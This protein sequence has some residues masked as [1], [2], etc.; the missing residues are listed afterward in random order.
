[1]IY[2]PELESHIRDKVKVL[3]GLPNYAI[4]I[5]VNDASGLDTSDLPACDFISLKAE[6]CKLDINEL[7]NVPT[8]VN[9][10]KTKVDDLDV[11]KL[12]TVPI[13]LKK[14]SDVVRKE[15]VRKAKFNVLN[16]KLNSL[17]NKIFDATTLIHIY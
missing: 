6:V 4:K 17:E 13:D 8:K 3:L 12:K 15:D 2:Y 7:V 14:L 11:G 10:L 16:T 9:N 5:Q 1:M